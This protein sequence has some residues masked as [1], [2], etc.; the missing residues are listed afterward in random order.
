MAQLSHGNLSARSKQDF[1]SNLIKRT[2][3][4]D[5][6]DLLNKVKEQLK[7]YEPEND[8]S[9][10][11]N[12]KAQLVKTLKKELENQSKAKMKA[13]D[14]LNKLKLGSKLNNKEG[15]TN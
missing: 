9:I 8:E 7:D 14:I 13:I 11:D 2:N 1:I 5:V 3:A 15:Y 12:D 6:H 4:K 10:P